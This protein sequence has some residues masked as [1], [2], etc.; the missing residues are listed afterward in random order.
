MIIKGR[1]VSWVEA[2]RQL[3]GISQ[4]ELPYIPPPPKDIEIKEEIELPKK[5]D[6]YKHVFAYLIKNRKLDADIVN[7]FVKSKKIYEDTHHNCVFVGYDEENNPKFASVRGTNTRKKFRRDIENSDKGYPFCQEG[8]S[9]TLCIFESAID[10]MSYLTLLKF[11]GITEF[12]HHMLSMGG[13][14]YI[15]IEKY[16]EKNPNITSLILCLDSD[17]EGNFFTQKIRER[18]GEEY[19]VVR[20]IPNGKDFND[21]LVDFTKNARTIE[22]T[23]Q[24]TAIEE[25]NMV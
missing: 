8:R 21:E 11:Y 19:K 25:E 20:H 9:D 14:S 22:K 15:P 7:Q 10:L 6:T 16:L 24:L 12:H 1:W 17:D 2:I 13:T 4:D 23:K 5:N 18:F 3:L